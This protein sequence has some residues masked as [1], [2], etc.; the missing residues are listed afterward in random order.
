VAL[1]EGVFGRGGAE[2]DPLLREV[3]SGGRRF[4]RVVFT[5]NARVMVSVGGNGRTLRLHERFRTAPAEVLRAIGAMYASGRRSDRGASRS[6]VREYLQVC[7]EAMH[8]D[9]MPP[10]RRRSRR[11]APG[12][13]AHIERLRR[14]F[15]DVN[16]AHFGGNLPA[17]PISLSG[18][19]KRRNGHFSPIPLEIVISR[20]LCEK[21][22]PGE[23]EM[24]LRHEMIHLWQHVDGR[25]P[26][27]GRD[28]REVAARIGV[29]PR[30]TRG[31]CWQKTGSRAET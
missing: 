2:E 6:V 8:A 27:H 12:D 28:F 25:R 23:S 13:D 1:I 26:G 24:T 30:A 14:E 11:A 16:L 17:V 5:R 3:R 20:R 15:D 7:A 18:R 21:A 22:A 29:H 31:V 19:M 4:D 10:P 9:A